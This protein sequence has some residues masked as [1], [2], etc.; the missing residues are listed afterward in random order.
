MRSIL[1]QLDKPSL[2]VIMS[3]WHF[4]TEFR[5]KS[6]IDYLLPFGSQRY[7]FRFSPLNNSFNSS[8]VWRVSKLAFL[9]AHLLRKVSF[10]KIQPQTIL[11]P[12]LEFRSLLMDIP[13]NHVNPLQ[14]LPSRSALVKKI[15]LIV[16][17]CSQ[18]RRWWWRL[19]LGR[20]S[21]MTLD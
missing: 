16:S 9:G 1:G 5:H 2:I 18:W 19:R 13:C 7:F 6:E 20:D 4:H 8:A 12:P 3:F 11:A 17:F 15:A 21:Q 10:Q 14:T